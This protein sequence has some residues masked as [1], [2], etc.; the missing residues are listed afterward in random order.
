MIAKMKRYG[1]AFVLALRFTL[2]GEK[3][4]ILQVRDEHRQLAAWWDQTIKL[5]EAVERAAAANGINSATMTIHA[6]RRDVSM[7]TI[8]SAVKFHAEREYPYLMAQNDPYAALT[9]QATNLN[10]RYLVMQLSKAVDARLQTPV[11]AL[12]QHL[13][14]VPS[15]N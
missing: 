7:A 13:A 12:A 15:D 1:R 8:L 10:D 2:R 5:V 3:P 11:E 4:P 9:I 14:A 6:D